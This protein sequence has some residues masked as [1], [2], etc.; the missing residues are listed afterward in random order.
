MERPVQKQSP[1]Y[2][3]IIERIN[4]L[5]KI[6]LI[7]RLLHQSDEILTDEL[8]L[9][10]SARPLELCGPSIQLYH[11]L[12]NK[13]NSDPNKHKIRDKVM[14]CLGHFLR[15]KGELDKKTIEGTLYAILDDIFN[16][17]DADNDKILEDTKKEEYLDLDGI[18]K[19]RYVIS[20]DEICNRFMREVDGVS[21]SARTFEC[22]D[23][24]KVT[25]DRLIS[26]C[27]QVFGGIPD[28]IGRDKDK[29]K[30]L[31]FDRSTVKE[32][33][34]SFDVIS[35]IKILD[36]EESFEDTD[37]DKELWSI[38]ER[39]QISLVTGTNPDLE[40]SKKEGFSPVIGDKHAQKR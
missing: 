31:A 2:R 1:K 9:N 40:G 26:R 18:Q 14:S 25:H 13:S 4:F 24:E 6:L 22:A 36:H 15:K 39:P 3:V 7:Y 11:T 27:K 35:E 29:R 10:I 19:M 5:H 28:N 8:P 23:F 32:A 17:M 33:G 30:A 38:F 12:N 37:E 34:E 20:Y 21:L 16:E